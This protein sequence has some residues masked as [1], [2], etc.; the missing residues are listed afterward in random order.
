MGDSLN[1]Q[2]QTITLLFKPGHYDILYPKDYLKKYSPLATYDV[3]FR[4][5]F[6]PS[7]PH[8]AAP[9]AAPYP[10]AGAAFQGNFAAAPMPLPAG[11]APL[12]PTFDDFNPAAFQAPVQPQ[13]RTGAMAPVPAPAP[14]SYPPPRAAPGP[15]PAPAYNAAPAVPPYYNQPPAAYPPQNA[16]SYPAYGAPAAYEDKKMGEACHLC[17]APIAVKDLATLNCFHKFHMACLQAKPIVSCPVPGC[18]YVLSAEE[19]TSLGGAPAAGATI[20]TICKN[21]IAD[22]KKEAVVHCTRGTGKMHKECFILELATMTDSKVLLTKSEDNAYRRICPVCNEY[23][24]EDAVKKNINS[25]Q[26]KMYRKNR[27]EREKEE[28]KLVGI[29]YGIT[30]PN[31]R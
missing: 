1:L 11:T 14:A 4:P 24:S 20:C 19:K 3:T 9:A 2:G 31:R 29:S 12:Y 22:V 23:V 30:D 21:P 26:F 27:D 25:D 8:P 7:G 17:G 13:W 5:V 10:G 15:V 16:Y 18:G 6:N 28:K